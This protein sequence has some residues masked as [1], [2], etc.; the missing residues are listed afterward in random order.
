MTHIRDIPFCAI[1]FESAG[2]A[3]GETDAPVQIGGGGSKD[4]PHARLSS[5]PNRNTPPFAVEEEE[6]GEAVVVMV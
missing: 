5:N 1:D 6:E 3:R 4:G 2:A